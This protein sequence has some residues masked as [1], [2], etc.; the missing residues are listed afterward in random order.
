MNKEMEC[1]ECM[2]IFD[3]AELER[4]D[5]TYVCEECYFR[6]TGGE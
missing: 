4:L 1:D 5:I 2:E 3:S 6:I